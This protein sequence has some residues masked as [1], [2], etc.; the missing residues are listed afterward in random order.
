MNVK[1]KRSDILSGIQRIQGV[2]ERR[3]TMPVL[4]HILLSADTE[5]GGRM[6][7]FAT[8]LE[9]SMQNSCVAEVIQPGRVTVQAKRFY[10]MI[11]EFSGEMVWIGAEENYWVEVRCGKSRFRI[12]GLPPE[13][14]P[15]QTTLQTEINIPIDPP[16]LSSLIRKTI[17]ACGEQDV[18]H[19]L[20]GI[21]MRF[22][23]NND[24]KTEIRLV[25]T[26]GHRL[27]IAEGLLPNVP[28]E[29]AS[30]QVILPRKTVLEMKKI[31]EEY[32]P[33][34]ESS[35]IGDRERPILSVGDNQV[36]FR[37]G[38]TVLTSRLLEGVY[39][40]YEK[41]IPEGNTGQISSIKEELEGGLRRVSLFAREKTGAIK[42]QLD[43]EQICLS[44]NHPEIG[45][46]REE[47]SA[48]SSG[49][50]FTTGFNAHYLIDAL[51]ALEGKEAVL[52]FKDESSPFLIREKENGFL[53]VIMP[54]R[55]LD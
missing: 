15:L 38:S 9:I 12:A 7:L 51:G 27:A 55:S 31:M 11:R 29:Q 3:N 42:F 52:E 19:I 17:F 54:M 33:S 45:E 21:L 37:C 39:P 46:A 30:K 10:E 36:V 49:D 43:G 16:L 48:R 41:V 24:G 34:P 26:D 44:S 13:E 25:A 50:G 2:V 20:N 8:D 1:L 14:F 32:T 23:K 22:N 35:P 5:S 4:S 18:R 53:T 40:P 47:V 6:T 28:W